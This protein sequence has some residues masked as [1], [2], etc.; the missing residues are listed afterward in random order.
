MYNLNNAQ[1]QVAHAVDEQWE[2]DPNPLLQ[3]ALTLARVGKPVFP[4]LADRKEPATPNGFKD[5]TCNEQTI[6]AWWAEN[7]AFNV[8]LSPGDCGWLVVDLD[9][10]KKTGADTGEETWAKLVA[11]HGIDPTYTVQTPSGGRHLYFEGVDKSSVRRIGP[12]VDVRSEGGYVLIPPSVVGGKPY[13]VGDDCPI[14]ELPVWVSHMLASSVREARTIEAAELDTP[15]NVDR[16]KAVISMT[17]PAVE[18]QGGDDATFRLVCRVRELGV[19]EAMALDL[20]EPWNETCAPPWEPDALAEKIAHAYAYAQNGVGAW[21]VA[22]AS[23]IFAGYKPDPPDQPP[24][25]DDRSRSRYVLRTEAMQDARPPITWLIDGLI[26]DPSTVVI[27]APW[28]SFKSFAALDIGL[29]VAS[30]E[31]VFGHF[32][33][34]RVGPVIYLAGEGVAGIE[35]ARRPAWRAAR[36]IAAGRALP[37]YTVEKVP[38]VSDADDVAACVQMV[39]EAI[40]SGDIARPV[41]IVVDTMARAMA[42]LNENDAGDAMRY[43]D[44]AEGLK[45]EFGSTVLTVAHE[46]KDGERGLR[47][48]S[49]FGGGFD[50]ILK[51]D[52]DTEGL[53]ATLS[54]PKVKDGSPIEPFALTGREHQLGN[55][56]KSLVFDWADRQDFHGAKA[57]A[58]TSQDVGTALKALRAEK[59]ETVTTELLAAYLAG[60]FSLDD[61]VV[62]AKARALARGQKTRF[63][64]YVAHAGTGGRDG[65]L[66]TLPTLVAD[67]A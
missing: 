23:E 25:N 34:N 8:A 2:I 41:L 37:F 17:A 27:H 22:P 4:C 43:L 19:S 42:G 40:Q 35:T 13:V 47:G 28:N 12:G 57:K 1:M 65:T 55:G 48:S 39:R 54:S 59:G 50:I 64:A 16:A 9:K 32:P 21:A 36:G 7:P 62:K 66:W 52:A 49:A 56:R 45:A 5:A 18:G 60:E 29:A 10:D 11:E 24:A 20:M 38:Q 26:Q 61:K 15:T 53:T 6:R 58:I 51:M 33:V 46:G 30:G 67:A 44:L 14:T 31:R 63:A 3:R